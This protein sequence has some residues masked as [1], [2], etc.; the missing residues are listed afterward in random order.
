V[1]TPIQIVGKNGNA[2]DVA[3]SGHLVVGEH[4]F[5]ETEFKLLNATAGTAFNYYSPKAN[6]QFIIKG[7]IAQANKDV[8][9]VAT[10]TVI[11]FEGSSAADTSA[12]KV[13]LEFGLTRFG[14]LNAP[15]LNIIV[16]TGKFINATTDDTSILMTIMGYYIPK[17]G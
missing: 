17:L 10:A 7:I 13:L 5:N 12:D 3:G 15:P 11:V 14:V 8:S 16:N 1:S 2:V 6:K 9:N 4:S